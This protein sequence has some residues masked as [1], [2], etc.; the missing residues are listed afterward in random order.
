[1]FLFFVAIPINSLA[2]DYANLNFIGFSKDG[3]FFAFEQYGTQ[4]GS[5]FPY[6]N[7]YFINT[8]KNSFAAAPVSIRIDRDG[9]TENSVRNKVNLAAAKK[10]RDLKI[11]KGNTGK[12][13]LSHLTTD[14]TFNENLKTNPKTVRFAEL[15]GSSY[16]KG[17]YELSLKS[18]L[19]K[20]KDCD[21]FEQE[22]FKIEL[23]LK[24][25]EAGTM[26]ILQKDA[27]LPKSRGC[28]LSYSI[29]DV[30]LYREYIAVFL[31]VLTPG[32]E[33]P[34]MRYM[35]VSGKMR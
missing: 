1:M 10:L 21:I 12:L 32:F 33:G 13:V 34:D 14:L 5:G 16:H 7:I 2:G 24:D 35:A 18:V 6:A 4:D 25:T 8:E 31:N 29:Q 27:D 30:Y 15:V 9:A 28:A 19:T 20:S 22:I 23:S 26:K 3:K 11:I 17:D